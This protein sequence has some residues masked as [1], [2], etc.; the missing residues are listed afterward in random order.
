MMWFVW[1]VVATRIVARGR[2]RADDAPT[3][4][5][6]AAGRELVSARAPSESLVLGFERGSKGRTPPQLRVPEF[7][8]LPLAHRQ[9]GIEG[10]GALGKS[11]GPAEDISAT[12]SGN[13]DPH[14]HCGP[15]AQDDDAGAQ[16]A[17]VD[18]DEVY[19]RLRVQVGLAG[20]AVFVIG[21]NRW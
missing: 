8:D 1:R 7:L 21:L 9:L 5:R 19:V 15:R 12:F 4:A 20:I 3:R 14:A 18:A 17:L 13:D 11:V 2:A 16:S 10:Y 6:L